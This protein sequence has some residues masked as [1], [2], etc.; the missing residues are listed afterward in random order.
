MPG[1]PSL[2]PLLAPRPCSFPSPLMKQFF[3]SYSHPVLTTTIVSLLG[4]HVSPH[5]WDPNVADTII[6]LPSCCNCIP[7]LLQILLSSPCLGE[8][9]RAT[10]SQ[11]PPPLA[12]WLPFLSPCCCSD[13]TGPF[14]IQATPPVLILQHQ[15]WQGSL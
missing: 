9:M 15:E 6:S 2:L 13:I 5:Q 7:P 14:S 10:V 12:F 1:R 11:P 4:P 3:M 8:I